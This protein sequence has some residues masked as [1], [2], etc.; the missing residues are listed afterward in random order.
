MV[1][2]LE[3]EIPDAEYARLVRDAERAGQTPE[4]TLSKIIADRYGLSSE[5]VEGLTL[6]K[7]AGIFNTGDPDGSNNE[8]I[9]EDLAKDYGRGL[10]DR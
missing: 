10:D 7:Y 3:L 6:L 9:D 8:R 2:K 4:V 5:K 1:R